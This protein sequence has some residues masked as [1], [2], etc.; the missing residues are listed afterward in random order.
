[1]QIRVGLPLTGGA[2]VDE[3]RRHA[4]PVLFSA[5]A[6]IRRAK[7]SGRV[8]F[9]LPPARKYDGMDT[10]LDSAGFVAM[11]RYNGFDWSVQQY[12]DL[13]AAND[14][15]W[16]A[17]LDCC[18]EP[19][20]A[21]NRNERIL[22]IAET[23]RLYAACAAAARRRGLKAPMPVLQ[24]WTVDDYL[25]SAD[26]LPAAEW[27]ALV[28]VGSVCR[29]NVSG[30]DGIIAIVDALDRALP[31]HVQLHLFGVKGQA[32]DVLHGHARIWSMDSM[33]WD[34][35]ARRKWP[36]GRT[37]AKRIR[38]MHRWRNAQLARVS[39]P[40]VG[41]QMGLALSG[42]DTAR[43]ETN[44]VLESWAE[45]VANGEIEMQSAACYMDREWVA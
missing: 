29:R 39:G 30:P 21:R 24:G 41:M 18:C 33:A 5:N 16:W 7:D 11:S 28:G 8:R 2:L 23:A 19:E 38:E 40:R 43:E 12:L 35:A 10:A 9:A 20:V 3:A 42:M 14:W 31:T 44:P 37:M 6:F 45:L 25:R 34:L 4:L 1:M 15:T 36:T 26:S 13:V 17:Q 27:P 22:R 32:L